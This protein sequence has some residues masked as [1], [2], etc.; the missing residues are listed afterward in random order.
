MKKIIFGL[1]LLLSITSVFASKL[2]ITELNLEKTGHEIVLETK[3]LGASSSNIDGTNLATLVGE[4]GTICSILA[5]TMAEA[6]SIVTNV[7]LNGN[8]TCTTMTST[9]GHITT[10]EYRLD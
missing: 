3:L 9:D 8:V 6:N 10:D 2:T 7:K 4:D 5:T 1:C